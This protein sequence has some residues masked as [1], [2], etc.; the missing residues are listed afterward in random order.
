MLKIVGG[1]ELHVI[2]PQDRV[3]TLGLGAKEVFPNRGGVRQPS[4]H[5][6]E[7][8]NSPFGLHDTMRASR[9]GTRVVL[10]GFE[11]ATPTR[12]LAGWRKTRPYVRRFAT[13]ALRREALPRP[14]LCRARGRVIERR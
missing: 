10:A 14:N 6:I 8:T 3:A 5:M 1:S 7:A 4:G 13:S 9:I 12:F 11:T 2:E